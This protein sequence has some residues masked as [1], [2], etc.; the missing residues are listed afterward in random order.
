[1]SNIKS[2]ITSLFL[3]LLFYGI[4]D[5]VEVRSYVD[6]N[7]ISLEDYVNLTIE[8]IGSDVDI[9]I[10]MSVVKDFQI[11]SRQTGTSVQIINNSV[12]KK[13]NYNYHLIPLRKG[14]LQIPPII[15]NVGSGTLKTKKIIVEVSEL[16]KT[17][18]LQ[19]GVFVE[20][21]ISDSKPFPGEQI[22]YTFKFYNDNSAVIRD[23]RFQSPNFNGFTVK[24]IKDD[25]SYVTRVSG[26]NH[27]VTEL[28]YVLIPLK[29][30]KLT[31]ESAI[32]QFHIFSGKSSKRRSI[33]DSFFDE[34]FFSSSQFKRKMLK[35]N[36]LE[37]LVEPLPKYTG[38]LEYTGLVG[39]FELKTLIED[40][41]IEMGD[42]TTLSVIIQ[43]TGN[44]MD[45]AKPVIDIPKG[46]KVYT[47]NPEE[48]I[49]MNEK[50][51]SGKK[52]FRFALVA[53]DSIEPG[54]YDFKPFSL[55]FFN[56]QDGKY[57]VASSRALSIMVNAAK[58]GKEKEEV[59]VFSAPDDTKLPAI[60]KRKV[61]F[62][63]RDILP[64]KKELD[65][66]KDDKALSFVTFLI[67]LLSPGL[68]FSGLWLYF[69]LINQN[70]SPKQLMAKRAQDALCKAKKSGIKRED[71]LSSL[72][73]ALIF[74]LYSKAGTKGESLTYEEAKEILR[75][76]K[77]TQET[78][79]HVISILK[80]IETAR[81]DGL[82]TDSY[83]KDELF[84][85]TKG[86]VKKLAT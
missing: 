37:I 64:I 8:V 54:Q 17:A 47:D 50:G 29:P 65:A 51:F 6:R 78:I 61:E 33:F 68:I 57:E 43:G 30:G 23:I 72:H 28:N 49:T 56:P 15:V 66:I 34:P 1:M 32:L 48:D 60:K 21:R 7:Q 58:F 44:I 85:L 84:N 76:K 79:D 20:A 12:T 53:I 52:V 11:L 70:I 83:T 24:K 77:S 27:N 63:G 4:S 82:A 36:P 19:Q 74:A 62:S 3:V 69:T 75:N 40:S 73:R 2:I 41:E 26:K 9:D 39:K 10:D 45:A 81:Y 55:L 67:L 80:K 71:F 86:A 42:S 13:T 22:I 18:K 31:I 35:S 46:F 38:N 59:K 5:A 14:A 16:S 25:K